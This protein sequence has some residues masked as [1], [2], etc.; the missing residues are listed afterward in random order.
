[1][2]WSSF[3]AGRMRYGWCCWISPCPKWAGRR[4]SAPCASSGRACC[5]L[6]SSGYNEVEAVRRF[7][8]EAVAGFIQ[9][10]YTAAR[11]AEKVR[12]ILTGG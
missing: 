1:M 7:T 6:L 4:P 12:Q 10:P 5:V 9:K 2:P 3:R 8:N 11:L